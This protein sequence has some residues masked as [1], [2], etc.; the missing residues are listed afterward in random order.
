MTKRKQVEAWAV[1]DGEQIVQTF[2]W[3]H[4]AEKWTQDQGGNLSDVKGL[5]LHDPAAEALREE[6][7]KE[8]Q[9]EMSDDEKK[10]C[11]EVLQALNNVFEN[12]FS[13]SFSKTIRELKIATE[14]L[15]TL[16]AGK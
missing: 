16:L 13:I 3:K 6:A 11:L 12:R 10:I 8:E 4:L 7:R 2:P 14:K 1:V 9:K 5:V 15:E